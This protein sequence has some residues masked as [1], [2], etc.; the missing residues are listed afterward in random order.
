VSS[1]LTAHQ[2]KIGHSAPYDCKSQADIFNISDDVARCNIFKKVLECGHSKISLTCCTTI[3]YHTIPYWPQVPWL[4][5]SA[6]GDLGH[7]DRLCQCRSFSNYYK[8]YF[9]NYSYQFPCRY[10]CNSISLSIINCSLVLCVTLAWTEG[11][12]IH[13][14]TDDGCDIN[15]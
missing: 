10:F 5:I 1:F 7:V 2:H 14:K 13:D 12:T 8:L 4:S 9:N 3:P 15:E 6:H 11:Q